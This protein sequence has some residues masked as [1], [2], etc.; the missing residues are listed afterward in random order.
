MK[1]ILQKGAPE[2]RE[3]SREVSEPEISSPEMKKCLEDMF[4]LLNNIPDGVALAAPQVGIN[5][6]FFVVAPRAFGEELP[7]N[8]H[9]VYIN[10]KITKKSSKK[11]IYDEGCLS[12]RGVYGKIKR[13]ANVTV[14][15][16]DE[17]G[18]KFTRGAGGLLAEIFQHEIDHLDGI[19]FID[20]ATDL[21]ETKNES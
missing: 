7:E 13:A 2:L 8:E 20:S 21:R 15:A 17:N 10:P 11:N 5:K 9:L 3:P 6:R 4:L 16:T 1:E 18:V 19:L 14:S 12:V